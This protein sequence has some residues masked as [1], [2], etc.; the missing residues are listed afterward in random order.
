MKYVC[1]SVKAKCVHYM[2]TIYVC[3]YTSVISDF[4]KD[5]PA[6]A[7]FQVAKLPKDAEVEI[8]AIALSGDLVVAVAG[9]CP[10]TRT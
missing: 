2:S 5:Q 8:E 6:R 7:T 1:P 3:M 9:P 10:C 4:T